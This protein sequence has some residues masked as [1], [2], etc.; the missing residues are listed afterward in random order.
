MHRV[1]LREACITQ[2]P[3]LESL[4]RDEV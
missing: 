2:T 3:E 4:R 1:K